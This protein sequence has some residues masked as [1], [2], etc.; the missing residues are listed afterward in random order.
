MLPNWNPPELFTISLSIPLGPKVVRTASAIN[1]QAFILLMSCG[2]PW[3]ES[4]PSFNKIIPGCC[5]KI[6]HQTCEWNSFGLNRRN[7]NKLLLMRKGNLCIV[8]ILPNLIFYVK[9][10]RWKRIFPPSLT[11]MF[12]CQA[13]DL[14]SPCANTDFLVS[15]HASIYVHLRWP[16][17][18]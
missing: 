15:F 3:E 18:S 17:P 9:H 10:R 13:A 12:C 14:L 11:I 5:Q 7:W 6:Q 16:K 4:V 1:W 2:T 8:E